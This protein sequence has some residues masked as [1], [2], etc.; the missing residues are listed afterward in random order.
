MK[1]ILS[2]LLAAACGMSALAGC[3]G[4]QTPSSSSAPESSS[5][6][7]APSSEA[8]QEP[9]QASE[10]ALGGEIT[11][12]VPDWAVPSDEM[13]D[14]FTEQ[15]GVEVVMNVVGWDDIRNKISIAAS[16]GAAAA[17]VV[18]VDWSWVGEFNSAGWLEPLEVSQE[19]IDGMPSIQSFMV[20]GQVLALP[21]ANDFRIAYYNQEQFEK[22]GITDAPKTWDEVYT[23]MKAIKEQGV[24]EYPYSMPMNADESATTSLIWLALAKGGKAFNDDGTLNQEAVLDALQFIDKAVK[25]GLVDPASKTASGMDTY[26]K[27]TAGEASFIVGPTS[28][29]SR[30]NDEK[31]SQVVGKVMPI[32]LPGATA[33]ST[34][35]F[36]LPEGVG[37]TK[38]SQ[39]KEGAKAFVKWFNSPET[40]VKL[41]EVQNTMPTRTAVLQQLIDNGK[42]Q[43]TGALLEQ[44]KL[45]MSPFP[46]GV[47]DYYSEMSNAIY[48]AVNEMVLGNKTPEEA[49][50]A[51]DAKVKELAQ[52]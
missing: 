27:L 20:E 21:Y 31:E 43:N 44:S 37:V 10:G 4:S 51:M 30:V 47:P 8:E 12:M 38:F 11:V 24:V 17:D 18:E 19:D 5:K 6:E 26:R 45:I 32:L 50:S 41:N 48:N 9:A 16:G 7:A 36:A 1:R 28:F 25:E 39:N 2:I 52:K 34:Q 49:F 46:G 13:L 35:T 22:A 23:A 40:Q 29:V 42:L 33:A 15:T 14:E 3:G